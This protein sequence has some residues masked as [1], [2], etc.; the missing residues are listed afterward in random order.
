MSVIRDETGTQSLLGYLLDVGQGD[1]C[2][3]CLLDVGPQH[4]NRQGLLHGGVAT[5]LLDSAMGAT[6]SLTV[7][8]TGRHPF[9]TVSLTVSF[10]APGQQGGVTATGVVTGKGRSLV[11][12]DGEL[13]HDDGTVIAR[14]TGVFKKARLA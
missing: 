5:V 7:D 8:E 12:L 10:L 4:M 6:A 1:G 3:R 2:A 11:F 14:A 13:V 9:S